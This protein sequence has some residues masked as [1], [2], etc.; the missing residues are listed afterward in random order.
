MTSK[1]D[2]NL[3]KELS[4]L[5]EFDR[6]SGR[7]RLTHEGTFL[8][9]IWCLNLDL[10]NCLFSSNSACDIISAVRL[11]KDHSVVALNHNKLLVRVNKDSTEEPVANEGV[12]FTQPLVL[13][14]ESLRSDIVASGI[15]RINRTSSI[16]R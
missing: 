12:L 10:K 1:Y 9:Q 15:A 8:I 11:K 2:F 13:N 6:A 14:H 4:K 5:F 7:S 16:K 3:L